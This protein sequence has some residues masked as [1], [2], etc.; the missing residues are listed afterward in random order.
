MFTPCVEAAWRLAEPYRW[1]K[2]YATEAARL[3]SLDFGFDALGLDEILAWTTPANM[4]SQRVMQRLG[5]A[6]VVPE[7]DFDHPRVPRGSPVRPHVVY[8]I[9]KAEHVANRTSAP[10]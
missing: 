3:R 9:K 4:P 5:M 2:G 6:R 7:L 10:P 8:R 1:G